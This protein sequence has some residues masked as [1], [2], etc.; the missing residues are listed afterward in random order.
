MTRLAVPVAVILIFFQ[1]P[2]FGGTPPEKPKEK[3]PVEGWWMVSY[4]SV[5]PTSYSKAAGGIIRAESRGSR[6]S[7]FKTVADNEKNSP[8]LAWRWK[9]SN[10]VRSAIETRKDRFDTAARVIVVFRKEGPF[11]KIE[12]GEPPGVRIEYIWASTLPKGKIFDDPGERNAKVAVLESG[13]EKAGQWV[14]ES[15][16]VRKD[17]RELFGSE[18]P[19]L[20]AIG[21]LTDTDHSNEMVTAYYSEPLLKRK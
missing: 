18:P 5:P 10:V 15:R 13:N 21:L 1:L 2:P 9:I 20:L 14:N 7:L 8:V 17:Y 16:N 11:G 12:G 3:P 19:S 4:F 6:S